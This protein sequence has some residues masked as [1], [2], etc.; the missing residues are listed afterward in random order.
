MNI[1]REISR[2]YNKQEYIKLNNFITIEKNDLGY[3]FNNPYKF[4]NDFAYSELIKIDINSYRSIMFANCN[5]SKNKQMT[6][7]FYKEYKTAIKKKKIL[8]MLILNRYDTY[9]KVV[10]R[11]VNIML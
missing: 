9:E 11:I 4:N 5:T 1:F 3:Y 10:N 8:L 7:F 6:G 2:P